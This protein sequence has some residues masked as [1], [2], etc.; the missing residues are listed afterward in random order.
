[1]NHGRRS[2]GVVAAP[3][4]L[5]T[6]TAVAFLL[7]LCSPPALAAPP[8]IT[9]VIAAQRLGT[10]LVDVTY[11]LYDPD[12]D[13]MTIA[14][15]LSPDGG[16]SFP[17]E[18]VTVSG[19][20][21]EG[22]TNGTGRHIEW[23]A[24][25]DYPGHVGNDY[26]VK[27]TAVDGTGY[28][29]MIWI[30]AGNVRM[31]QV[32]IAEPVQDFYVEGFWIDRYEVPNGKYKQFID[33]GG[34]STQAWWNPVGWAWRVMYEVTMPNVWDV[35]IYHGGGI[36]GNETFPVTGVSWW[37]ADAYCRWAGGRLPTEA[38]W[39]KAAKGG[40]ETHGDPGQCD[41]LDTP[42]Y[43]W[44]EGI[45]EPQANYWGS[46]D[47][48]DNNGYTTPV[49]YYDGSNHGGYLTIGSP[50]PYG[51][52]DVAGNLL[53]WCSTKYA[54]YP[55][56]PN[57]GRED[58]PASYNDC[59]RVVRGGSCFDPGTCTLRCAYR[60]DDYPAFQEIGVGFRCART[61]SRDSGWGVS[62]PFRLDTNSAPE[63]TNVVAA[64]HPG[65]M[66][67]DV[68]YDLYDP[69][70]DAMTIAL[71]L[72]PDG[73][74]TFPIQCVTVSGDVGE[75][76]TNGT[77]RHIE[78]DAGAD[79]PG[80]VGDDYVVKVTAD[81]GIGHEG[82]IWIPAG[83]VRMGQVG[84]AEPVH[85]FFAEGFWIDRYEVP[86]GKYKQFIDAG[87][88][89]TQAWWN[90]VGWAWRVANN[91]TLPADWNNSARHGGGIPGNDGFPVN[92]VSWWEADAYCRWTGG[93]L[94][95]EAEWEK[96]A[97]G[98][99]ETHGD[100]YQCDDSDTPTYPWGEGISG[101]QANY[102][103]SGDPYENNGW[104]T[105]V[106]YYD[107]SN[108][109]G[110]QT[111]DSPSPYGLYDVA[112][113]I[114]EWCSTKY[115]SYPYDPNDGREDPPATSTELD[116][117]L[118]GGASVFNTDELQCANR[119]HS[120]HSDGRWYYIGFRCAGT[121]S[122]EAGWGAS[123]TYHLDTTDPQASIGAAER[124]Q[125]FRASVAGPS[126]FMERLVIQVALPGPG[127]L[128]VT[129]IDAAGRHVRTLV[130]AEY[131]AGTHM[132]VWDGSKD[133]G[134]SAP[135]GVYFVRSSFHGRTETRRAMLIR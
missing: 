39:E 29:W 81:E 70:G 14:L 26:V 121:D 119:G 94:P 77:G 34:Y 106:G 96:A 130:D 19:D 56:N 122:S 60:N 79:Y 88:Y 84:I 129:I 73:G 24:G 57:D 55:Y 120:F 114:W 86:N 85:D 43:P 32:G 109:S 8:E 113:N 69:H 63:V 58:P 131:P 123:P 128:G 118:R 82:M 124:A 47:P 50:S 45:S 15:Y 115:A 89:S 7:A 59:C 36:P 93:R 25:A 95:T 49:G 22:V 3:A 12:G 72:S 51:L 23:D 127:A 112:G 35:A 87:G 134:Q 75:G 116:R 101:P 135:A 91:I 102:W 61:A 62:P 1:M 46:G 104:S 74:L 53:E 21:G 126:I 27:V 2:S 28:G 98:G 103:Q 80:H 9:N 68:T 52:Y 125:G 31:G 42:T 18:C 54:S 67:V 76:V 37:E 13:A 111:I 10:K 30:P 6:L 16:Q 44:G 64:Q 65:T 83:N 132:L 4:L 108:H 20:V 117:V 5:L 11:D 48:Y 66:L 38:E 17:V 40:C 92:S 41:D 133:D 97:K 100:P 110:Y 90:P 107:G 71:Y 105:P 78:W 99:C 33:A